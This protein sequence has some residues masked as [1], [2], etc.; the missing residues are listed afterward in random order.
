ML[1]FEQLQ[2][3]V[4]LGVK[5]ISRR[6]SAR[7]MTPKKSE[8][9][10]QHSLYLWST[11]PSVFSENFEKVEI[12]DTLLHVNQS[13]LGP[14]TRPG[15]GLQVTADGFSNVSLVSYSV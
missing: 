13:S 2:F 1:T 10:S 14:P 9:K 5:Y 12:W 15:R 8:K 7:K 4:I 11:I 6:L 3:F